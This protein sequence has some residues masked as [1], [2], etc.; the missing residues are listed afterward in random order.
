[1]AKFTFTPGRGTTVDGNSRVGWGA[2]G[3]RGPKGDPGDPGPAGDGGGIEAV[4]GVVT[5]DGTG[6]AVREFYCTGTATIHGVAFAAGDTVVW[7]RLPSGEWGYIKVTGWTGSASPPSASLGADSASGLTVTQPFTLAGSATSVNI[8]W[9]DGTTGSDSSTPAA[10]TYASAGSYNAT[11]TPTNGTVNGTPVVRTYVVSSNLAPSM[12]LGAPTIDYLNVTQPFTTSDPESSPVTVTAD[13]DDGTTP[14]IVTSP[15]VHAYASAGTYDAT[16]TPNDGTTNGAVRNAT[17]TVAPNPLPPVGSPATLAAAMVLYGAAGY[18]KLNE[19]TGTTI[20]DYS[21]NS[22]HG[23]L[24]GTPTTDYVLAGQNGYLNL[25]SPG[26]GA[27]S[28]AVVDIPNAAAFSIPSSGAITVF[29]CDRVATANTARV[30][31][32]KG[33]TTGNREWQ[34]NVPNSA[35][36]GMV[37]VPSGTYVAQ[38]STG[39]VHATGVWHGVATVL[40]APGGADVPIVYVDSGTPQTVTTDLQPGARANSAEG[41]RI[42]ASWVGAVGHVAVFPHA[43]SAAHIQKLMDLARAEGIIP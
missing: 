16:F 26:A 43:L 6:E 39:N 38:S 32:R 3:P 7:R 23:T 41:I 30:L 27:A 37:T 33:I 8:A 13:W 31:V 5:L 28:A 24:S 19:T 17:F 21:G 2:T 25:L 9:G 34:F 40:P 12:T 10:H 29:A 14:A 11:F 4:S 42:G 20:T 35:V 36:R 1:M 22:R 18:W 15:A